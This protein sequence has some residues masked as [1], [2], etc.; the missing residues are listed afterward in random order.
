VKL[1]VDIGNS[2]VKW[3]CLYQGKFNDSGLAVHHGGMPNDVFDSWQRLTK[4][5]EVVVAN[6]AG[7]EMAL[8]LTSWVQ[9]QWA[10]DVSAPVAVSAGWGVRNAYA[11]A[12]KLGVDRWASLIAARQDYIGHSC[13]VVDC[14]TALTIDA[15]DNDGRHLGGLIAPGLSMMR[16]ALV[17][18]TVGIVPSK[19]PENDDALLFACNTGEA[20]ERGTLNA[21]VATIN[22]AVKNI[23]A[24]EGGGVVCLLTGGDGKRLLP[25]LSGNFIFDET[26]VLKGLAIIS[27]EEQ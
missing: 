13:C 23:E 15:L 19:N 6:V 26:L 24:T 8:E 21:I 5:T 9:E 11:N 20:V 22:N 18:N 12:E 17:D 3:A 27:G 10:V 25:Y 2:S 14:G 1:L 16:E 4:P 7:S